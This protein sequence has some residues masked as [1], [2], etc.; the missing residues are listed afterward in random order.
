MEN[1]NDNMAEKMA[2]INAFIEGNAANA[3][4]AEDLARRITTITDDVD[5]TKTYKSDDGKIITQSLNNLVNE[6]KTNMPDYFTGSNPMQGQ[7]DQVD[8]NSPFFA[9]REAI[10]GQTNPNNPNPNMV[11]YRKIRIAQGMPFRPI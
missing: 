6:M 7:R 1:D 9:L 5:G 2:L 3:Y 11:V 10:A 8:G 4:A